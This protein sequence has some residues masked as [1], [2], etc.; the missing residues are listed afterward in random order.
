MGGL[1]FDQGATIR[2]KF[3]P[4]A[5]QDESLS[6]HYVFRFTSIKLTKSPLLGD[7][8]LL[9]AQEL[10]LGP[11]MVSVTCSLFCSLVRMDT[12]TWSM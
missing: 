8:D 1:P 5:I 2:D 3:D 11:V 12:M 10:E 9:V 7:M 6:C 4:T